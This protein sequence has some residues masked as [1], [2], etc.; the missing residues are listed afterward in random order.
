M[1]SVTKIQQ[2]IEDAWKKGFD[3]MGAQQF[4]GHLKDT[5]KWIGASDVCAMF[6]SLRIK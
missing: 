4:G 2:L 3:L 6:S 1:P 5:A